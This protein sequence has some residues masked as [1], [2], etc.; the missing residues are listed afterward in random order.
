MATN[1][2]THGADVILMHVFR[3]GAATAYT[4]PATVY[5]SLHTA[6]P[7]KTGSV[8]AEVSGGGY[9]REAV[10]FGA[11]ATN[12]TGDTSTEETKNALIDWVTASAAWGTITHVGIHDAST[13]AGNMLA[14]GPLATQKIVGIG[15]TF[16]IPA[17]DLVLDLG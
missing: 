12:G 9:V 16:S 17:N 3:A 13:G 8:A 11:I 7:T 15:D 5:V 4:Q 10:T 1:L 14:F 2:T 6:D